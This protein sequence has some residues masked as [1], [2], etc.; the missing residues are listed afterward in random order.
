MGVCSDDWGLF[1]IFVKVSVHIDY[2]REFGDIDVFY[3]VI[4]LLNLAKA[5]CSCD[6]GYV[7]ED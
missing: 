3:E 7:G 4:G 5:D 1:I 6:E 2:S